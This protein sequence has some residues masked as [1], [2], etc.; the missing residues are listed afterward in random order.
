MSDGP[1]RRAIDTM[2]SALV[3]G[4]VMMVYHIDGE[5]SH[6]KAQKTSRSRRRSWSRNGRQVA[7]EPVGANRS[8][9]A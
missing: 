8:M 6:G 5:I 2:V 7:K 3:R 9:A 1:T 4:A